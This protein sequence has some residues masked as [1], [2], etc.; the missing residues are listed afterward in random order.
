MITAL[1]WR[2]LMCMYV[3]QQLSH[4]TLPEFQYASS[5]QY[6]HAVYNVQLR[7]ENMKQLYIQ[8][9]MR[10]YEPRPTR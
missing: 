3:H 5:Q 8:T 10:V 2:S 9:Y 4:E 6:M 7:L 1:E